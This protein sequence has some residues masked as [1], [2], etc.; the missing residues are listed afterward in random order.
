[1]PPLPPPPAAEA[2][3]LLAS[4]RL[5]GGLAPAVLDEIASHLEWSLAFGGLN[6]FRQGE[7]GDGLYLV[8]SGRL[9][10]VHE[11]G[12]GR[13]AVVGQK[14]RGDSFGELTVLTGEPATATIRALR[15]S[16]LARLSR[17][18]ADLLLRQNPEVVLAVTR[19]LA[20]WLNAGPPEPPRGCVAVALVPANAG[21]GDVPLPEI[22]DR[23]A[24][25]LAPFGPVLRL[26]SR[27]VDA[28]FGAGAA[29]CT[30]G[31]PE[32][33]RIA[34]WVNAQEADHA[35]ILYEADAAPSAWTRRCLR[36]AD[37][38]V[39]VARGDRAPDLEPAL[40]L[41]AAELTLLEQDQG[42]QLESLVLL[43]RDGSRR[44]RGTAGWLALRPFADHHHLRL[45]RRDDFDRL[46]RFLT[47]NSVGLVLGGGG[48]RGFAHIGVIRALEEAGIPID[49]IGG[50]S[51]GA[52]VAAQYARGCPWQELV[53][54]NRRGW[55]QM[56]PTKVYTLP[57]ISVLSPRKA[58]KM[59]D[60]MYGQEHIEDLWTSFFCVSTNITRTELVVHRSGPVRDWVSAS[61]TLPGVTPPVVAPGGDLLVD[62]GVLNNLPTDV[63]RSLGPGPIVAVDVSATID[64]RADPS[65]LKTPSPWQLLGQRF[66]RRA[67]PRP[68]PNIL[69]LIHRAALLASDVYAKQA[70]QEV[71]LYIDLPMDGFDMFGMEALERI[72]EF[73]YDYARGQLAT[74]NIAGPA[75]LL[76]GGRARP[77]LPDGAA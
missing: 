74:A 54:V 39:V 55:V 16:V 65:Y 48:A 3:E 32:H 15:D 49:R 11:L 41:L 44:P 24:A 9:A 50:A 42:R 73:G 30:D 77:A 70:K 19:L 69:R 29:Q 72:V 63:M 60:M 56:A 61:M 12:G 26:D 68:F 46:A 71:E 4:T 31:T 17:E 67:E 1:M 22:A 36:Q 53:D 57:L 5:F 18:R 25:S 23:L 37:R 40:G 35:V 21:R 28:R 75:D 38:I 59:L 47:G 13:E 43:H 64:V 34:E 33:G 76:K 27:R 66:R 7:V 10:V 52:V 14:G 58:E 2:R 51:M 20:G 62:G 45:D 6:V 8:A